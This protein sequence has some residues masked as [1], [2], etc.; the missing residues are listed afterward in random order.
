MLSC[1]NLKAYEVLK[2][3]LCFPVRKRLFKTIKHV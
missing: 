2:I 3:L 1:L